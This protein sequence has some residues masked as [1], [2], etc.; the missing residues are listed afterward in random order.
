MF[1]L[2]S[3]E[4]N[5]EAR[6]CR[7]PNRILWESRELSQL[8]SAQH[9]PIYIR[10]DLSSSCFILPASSNMSVLFTKCPRI[11]WFPAVQ[12]F[13]GSMPNSSGFFHCLCSQYSVMCKHSRKQE[14]VLDEYNLLQNAQTDENQSPNHNLTITKN[15]QNWRIS[16]YK[17]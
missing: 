7:T 3:P 8:L 13:K 14:E 6:E 15:V 5:C 16:N 9:S 11:T 1:P 17:E 10:T 12:P 2:S 4:G